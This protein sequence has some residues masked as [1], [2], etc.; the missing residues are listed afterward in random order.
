M[1]V[2]EAVEK[3]NAMKHGDD[4]EIAHGEA[5]N[6]LCELLRDLG[7]GAVSDAFD[8]AVDRVGFWYA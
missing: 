6:I 3:L 8:G 2:Q 5:E 1:N 7:Y 4:E